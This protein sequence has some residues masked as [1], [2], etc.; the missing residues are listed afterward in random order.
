MQDVVFQ[1]QG[2]LDDIIKIETQKKTPVYPFIG[3]MGN[4]IKSAKQLLQGSR[5]K[6]HK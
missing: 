4:E 5:S 2:Y 1:S 3:D 6:A